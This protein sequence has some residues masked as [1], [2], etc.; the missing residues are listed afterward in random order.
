LG[1]RVF[2]RSDRAAVERGAPRRSR[3]PFVRGRIEDQRRDDRAVPGRL[4][5]TGVIAES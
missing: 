2:E 4:S 1:Q 3:D 5:Q